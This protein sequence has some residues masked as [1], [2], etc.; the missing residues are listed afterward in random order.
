MSMS[1]SIERYH[2]VRHVGHQGTRPS[3]TS[4]AEVAKY[5]TGCDGL[6]PSSITSGTRNQILTVNNNNNKKNGNNS[7]SDNSNRK[8]HNINKI[9][10][11]TINVRTLQDDMKLAT[12]IKSA[13]HLG[14]DIL[15]MQEV[16][17]TSTGIFVFDDESVKGWQLI[18]SGH[19]LKKEH[20][21]GILPAPHVKAK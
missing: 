11:S 19:K 17:R 10:I 9:R 16:R 1:R 7:K 3:V 5:A 8:K 21:V 2:I 18:W 14:M 20:G 13:E 12:A 6:S 15:A 4:Q